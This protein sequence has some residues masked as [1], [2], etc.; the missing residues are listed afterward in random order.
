MTL[1]RE[2][3]DLYPSDS[4]TATPSYSTTFTARPGGGFSRRRVLVGAAGVGALGLL[5]ACGGKDGSTTPQES[6]DGGGAAGGTAIATTDKV[7]ANGGLIVT[8]PEPLVITQPASG[9]F[10]CFTA[11]CTHQGCT[12]GSVKDNTIM[13]PCHGSTYDASTGDVINGPATK[14]LAEKEITVTGDQITL[15]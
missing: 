6:T 14:A 7:P 5:A 3:T 2:T 1:D 13:C 12:V 8:S 9:Q 11:V 15:A 4:S 10:K